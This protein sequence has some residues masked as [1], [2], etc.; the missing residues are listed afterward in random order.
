MGGKAQVYFYK[1]NNQIA[2]RQPLVA[3]VSR[4]LDV[5]AG[6]RLVMFL[7]AILVL[8]RAAEAA[9][10][11]DPSA[12]C[13]HACRCAPGTATRCGRAGLGALAASTVSLNLSHNSLRMLSPSA[14]GNLTSLRRLWLDGNS[15]TFLAPG[16][17]EALGQLRELHLGGNGRL[18]ALHP[19][20]F[21]GLRNLTSLD[22]SRCNVFEIHPLLF[23]HLPSLRRLDLASNH[24]RYVPQA[25]GNLSELATLSLEGNHIEAVGRD[26]LRDL[27]S[28]QELN[29]RRNRIWTIQAGAFAKLLRLGVLNLGHNHIA[30]L[31]N[32]LFD[33]LIQLRT[34]HLE[35]NRLT[36]IG[37][38]LGQLPNLRSLYLNN[39]QLSSL[40]RSAFARS[41]KLHL[42]HL[43][44]NNL[45]SLPAGLLAELPRLKHLFLS[46]NP[47]RC[48][49]SLFWTLRRPAGSVQGLPC[50]FPPPGL[51]R[52]DGGAACPPPPLPD[53]LTEDDYDE[54]VIETLGVIAIHG[55]SF[56]PQM[57]EAGR[58]QPLGAPERFDT[59]RSRG[60]F[61]TSR[62]SRGSPASHSPN[63][64]LVEQEL[65]LYKHGQGSSPSRSN[66]THACT[67]EIHYNGHKMPAGLPATP[68]S[69]SPHDC[70]NV[71]AY[72]YPKH[73]PGGREE[74]PCGSRQQLQPF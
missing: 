15:L 70:A 3:S 35:A 42:L 16:T 26:S 66:E 73:P 32:R 45:S 52:A 39:N 11:A 9:L 17:F 50:T 12:R 65:L 72:N 53:L 24:M 43:S 62:C 63:T 14:F 1:Q 59:Y 10:S 44:K 48:D 36:G 21:R 29:L 67:K 41:A 30:H 2:D 74:Q 28:L 49:C 23:S 51:L 33:G 22:L 25:F 19:N 20:A 34:L 27:G 5:G 58:Q 55:C 40:A 31:P 68:A 60:T 13:P 8:T 38:T 71:T 56:Y 69:K 57:T 7:L 54:E 47:W 61:L 64:T 6:L 18:T 37:C 46:R 4:V